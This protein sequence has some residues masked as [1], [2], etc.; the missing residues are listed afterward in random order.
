[1]H[2]RKRTTYPFPAG[3]VESFQ[4]YDIRMAHNPHDLQF[5]VLQRNQLPPIR[6]ETRVLSRLLPQTHL[7]TLVLK[8]PFDGSILAAGRHLRL[9]DNPER[10]IA[11]DLALRILHLLGFPGQS[12]LDLFAYHFC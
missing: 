7:E 9:E 1:M 10:A 3:V 11:H 6:G 5:T 8:H 12:V 2:A 4:L